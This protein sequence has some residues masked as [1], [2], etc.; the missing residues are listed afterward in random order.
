MLHD[1]TVDHITPCGSLLCDNDLPK[2]VKN[3]FCTQD[4]LQVLCKDCH[5]TKTAEER[6]KK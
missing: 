2:F 6:K 4:R 5:K 1:V 3:L